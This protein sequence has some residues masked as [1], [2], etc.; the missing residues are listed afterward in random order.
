MDYQAAFDFLV[1]SWVFM[2]LENKGVSTKV[3]NRLKNLYN[4]NLSIVVVNNIAGK[5]V[6]NIRLSLLQGDKPSMFVNVA[7]MDPLTSLEGI[8]VLV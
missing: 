1:M 6:R 5:T 2:V 4:E 8:C 7:L 3:I